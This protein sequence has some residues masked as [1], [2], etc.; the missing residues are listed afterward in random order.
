MR[1]TSPTTWFKRTPATARATDLLP[2]PTTSRGRA[3]ITGHGSGRLSAILRGSL[4][5][6]TRAWVT[7]CGDLS[8][9]SVVSTCLQ[10]YARNWSSARWELRQPTSDGK[11]KV[12]DNDAVRLL[13][14]PQPGV[15]G[16]VWWG[17][18]REN[19]LLQGNAYARKVRAGGYG[20]VVGLQW[21]A[22]DM[23]APTDEGYL[24]TVDGRSYPLSREDVIHLRI[25]RDPYD[26]RLGRAPLLSCLREIASDNAGSTMAYGMAKNNAV[27]SLIIS[28]QRDPNGVGAELDADVARTMKRRVSEDFSGDNAGGVAVLTDAFDVER[29]S[30][31]PDEMA[32]DQM[33]VKPEERI[34]SVLGL[35]CMVLGLG[36]G[37]AHNTYSNYEEARQAAWED[38]M[39]PLMSAFAEA[40]TQGLRADF[41]FPEGA[42]LAFDLSEVRALADDVNADGT[43]AAALYSSGVVDRATA[44][45]I[46]GVESD[47]ADVGVFHPKADP[48]AQTQPTAGGV[49]RSPFEP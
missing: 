36:A 3:S 1:L 23:V 17:W 2:A 49:G 10:W 43:R 26:H 21:L 5:G 9:N 7:E 41:I 42:Y 24:Y 15:P 34:T 40:M 16:S 11:Y 19:Y 8:L 46:A 22:A 33:R 18:V 4:P 39:L 35:N 12:V 14:D 48:D 38:G 27:P 29:V 28:P 31:S 32:L 30:F 44:K 47:P 45:Q 13:T 25:G 6:S 37:L 20:P